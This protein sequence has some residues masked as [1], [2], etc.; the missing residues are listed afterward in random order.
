MGLITSLGSW[1]QLR[2]DWTPDPK[3]YPNG[4]QPLGEAVKQVGLGFFLSMEPETADAGSALLTQHPNWFLPG[5]YRSGLLNLGDPVARRG[6]TDIVSKLITDS[7]AS[8]YH[9]NSFTWPENIWTAADAPNRVGMSEINYITGLYQFW[10]DLRAR[11]PGLIIDNAAGDGGERLDIEAISRCVSLFGSSPLDSYGDQVT[12]RQLTSVVPLSG[13]RLGPIPP[14]ALPGS[15]AQLYAFRSSYGAGWVVDSEIDPHQPLDDTLR[16][17]VEEYRQVRPYF[18]GDFYPLLRWSDAQDPATSASWI[19][20]Q[21][22]R[23]DLKAGV[24]LLLRRERSDFNSVQPDLHGL[25][26]KAQYEVEIRTGLAK[27]P[28]RQM[29][30][31]E[32]SKLPITIPDKP[33]SALLFYR[34]L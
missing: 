11:H 29:F 4:L 16:Q 6:I 1:G 25:D 7:G 5:P 34:Q 18:Q 32:L 12:I 20:W 27:G 21:A 3:N 19:G 24:A 8:W 15:S 30:G 14:D 23:P 13:G 17:V 28:L 10:D 26:P 33:G 22:H 2:G 9:Q 31:A